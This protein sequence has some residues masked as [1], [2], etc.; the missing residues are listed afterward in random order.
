M[1]EPRW[2]GT[3]IDWKA[4]E[5]RARAALAEFGLEDTVRERVASLSLAQQAIIESTGSPRTRWSG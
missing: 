3:Q 4:E 1:V 5:R 2:G